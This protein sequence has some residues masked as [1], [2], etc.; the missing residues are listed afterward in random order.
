MQSF[1]TILLLA[2]VIGAVH[3]YTRE[4]EVRHTALIEAFIY[5]GLAA[6]VNDD[7]PGGNDAGA[8]SYPYS[9]RRR[10]DVFG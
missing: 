7:L 9:P 3:W 4:R 2:R 8:D 5:S 10:N 1:L 6:R